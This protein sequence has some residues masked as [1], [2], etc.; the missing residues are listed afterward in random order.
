ML[1]VPIVYILFNRPDA[2]RSTFL[3]IRAQRPSRLYLIADGPRDS[4]PSDV[5]RCSAARAA[6]ESLIDWPCEVIRDYSPTN[7]GSGKRISSGLTRALGLLGE[8][9]IIE[10]DILPHPD[11][12]TFC[13]MMLERYRAVPEVHGISGYNPIGRYLPKERCAVPSLTHL[14][15]GW[16]TWNRAWTAY[17]GN[18]E[19]WEDR[20]V[21]DRIKSYVNDPLYFDELVRAFRVVEKREVDAWDYQWVYTMLYEQRYAIVSS[22][23]LVENLGF[24]QDATHTFYRPAFVEGL[25]TYRLPPSPL[26]AI[27]EKPDRLFDRLHWPVYLNGS[28]LK[29]SF[30]RQLA[31]RNRELTAQVLGVHP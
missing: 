27:D 2:V 23:N 22:V 8:A 19:G 14:T 29:I 20:A 17:R 9:I 7:L 3:A 21:R 13:E 28:R 1:H 5:E 30:L 25:K 24:M 12:F 11:F 15:W 6:V 10:D 31:V 26:P 18:L 4:R 16:A